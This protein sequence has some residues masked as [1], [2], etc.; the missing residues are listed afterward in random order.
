MIIQCRKCKHALLN[1]KNC[2]SKIISLTCVIFPTQPYLILL[3]GKV[4][5]S[6]II[7]LLTRIQNFIYGLDYYKLLILLEDEKDKKK[8]LNRYF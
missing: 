3:L 7:I 8:Y 1:K 4:L 6:A 2:E 5:N